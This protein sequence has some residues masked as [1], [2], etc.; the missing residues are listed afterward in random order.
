MRKS[1]F[2]TFA[3]FVYIWSFSIFNAVKA[4]EYNTAV[5]GHVISETIKGTDI[6]HSKLLEQELQKLAHNYAIEMANILQT[7]LPAIL[8]GIAAELRMKADESYKCKLL[9]NGGMSDGCYK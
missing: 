1:L 7:Y 4:N 9:E 5:I 2:I 6:D 3:V 8:D